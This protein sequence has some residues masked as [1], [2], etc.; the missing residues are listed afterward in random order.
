MSPDKVPEAVL[1]AFGLTG[2]VQRLPGGQGDSFRCGDAV[3]KLVG[4]DEVEETNWICGSLVSLVCDGFRIPRPKLTGDQLWVADG[5]TATEFAPGEA[6]PVGRW[7]ELLDASRRFHE[8]LRDVPRPNFL[9][10]RHH[11][12]AVA[13]RVAWAESSVEPIAALAPVVGRCLGLL[14]PV[15]AESQIVHGDLS[16]NVLFA[17]GFAP[18]IIDFSPYWRPTAWAEAVVAI[19]GMLWYDAD[20]E[21]FERAK[22]DHSDFSQMFLRALIFRIVAL[23]ERV[24]QTGG[25][26]HDDLDSFESLAT[27][28]ER[29]C[30]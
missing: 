22:S 30:A 1:S 10:R 6:D 2:E 19:D 16:G 25:S 13:D 4:E 5:W 23:N 11:P 28:C 18:A 20:D 17:D 26:Y 14:S 3:L 15:D 27:K 29:L 7:P 21:L 8:T 24:R 12:W 9:D